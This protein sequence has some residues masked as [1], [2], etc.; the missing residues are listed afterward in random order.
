ME[1]IILSEHR[2]TRISQLIAFVR[3][4]ELKEELG[5]FEHT[6]DWDPFLII[7]LNNGE[8]IETAAG[9]SDFEILNYR[10]SKT[11]S[12]EIDSIKEVSVIL[13]DDSD[14]SEYKDKKIQIDD[15]KSVQWLY[16]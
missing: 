5:W 12:T 14:E 15:I 10:K 16:H 6:S 1:K 2:I 7:T 3:N 9:Y 8:T 4:N 13:D 11:I